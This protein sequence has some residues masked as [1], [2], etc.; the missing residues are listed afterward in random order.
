MFYLIY[1]NIIYFRIMDENK[2]FFDDMEKIFS[3]INFFNVM[4]YVDFF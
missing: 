3:K 1:F 4:G 2:L